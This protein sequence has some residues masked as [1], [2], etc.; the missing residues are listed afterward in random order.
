MMDQ[1]D[2]LDEIYKYT[3]SHIGYIRT[4]AQTAMIHFHGF[5]GLHFLDVV[6]HP[7]NEWEQL[8]LLEQLKTLDFVEMKNL[9]HWLKSSNATVVIFALKLVYVY[10]QY[11]VHDEVVSCL[12]HEDEKV[13]MQAVTTLGKIAG[14]YTASIL[15]AHYF[16]EHFTNRQNILNCLLSIASD[17]EKDFLM[18]QLD[19]END[20]LKLAAARVIAKCYDNGFEILKDRAQRDPDPYQEIYF[21]LKSE[22][23]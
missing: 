19:D 10:Q 9:V 15:A 23:L 13:R 2:M 14:E 5:E 4:E 6:T 8:K 20:S 11:Q 21:H 22:L 7:V 12:E 3:N 17:S 1:K 18:Q 16:K